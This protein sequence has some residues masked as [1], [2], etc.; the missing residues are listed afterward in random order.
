VSTRRCWDRWGK[1]LHELPTQQISKIWGNGKTGK[2]LKKLSIPVTY[3]C[4]EVTFRELAGG[5]E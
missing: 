5:T 2:V 4:G 1:K 3:K